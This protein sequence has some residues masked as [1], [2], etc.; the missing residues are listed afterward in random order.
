MGYI[1]CNKSFKGSVEGQTS[2]Y[3]FAH[4]KKPTLLM[5]WAV[6]FLTLNRLFYVQYFY[7]TSVTTSH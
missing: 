3:F 1:F 6:I 4:N 7:S 2:K 5:W